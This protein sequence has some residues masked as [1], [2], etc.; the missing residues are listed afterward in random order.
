MIHNDLIGIWNRRNGFALAHRG[1][2]A[3]GD[4]GILSALLGHRH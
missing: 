1:L 4:S 3:T 2:L